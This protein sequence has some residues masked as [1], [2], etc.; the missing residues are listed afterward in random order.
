MLQDIY[1]LIKR[2]HSGKFCLDTFRKTYE[3]PICFSREQADY[4]LNFAESRLPCQE[5]DEFVLVKGQI[6]INAVS[7]SMELV[8]V[9]SEQYDVSS[10]EVIASKKA[11]DRSS[12]S[13]RARLVADLNSTR[14]R[15]MES[16]LARGLD[17]PFA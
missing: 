13:Y 4:L 11:E 10:W 17:Q 16:R 5:G 7:N 15:L 12:S 6:D 2:D 1:I 14:Q 9:V 8:K 3:L